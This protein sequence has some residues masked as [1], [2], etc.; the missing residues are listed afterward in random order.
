MEE[1]E[2]QEIITIEYEHPK[3]WH[4]VMANLMDIIIFV[5]SVI[6]VFI[7][8]RA[9]VVNTPDYLTKEAYLDK[10]RLASGLYVK[11]EKRIITLISYL[12]ENKNFAPSVKNLKSQEAVETYISYLNNNFGEDAAHDFQKIYDDYRLNEGLKYEGV[13]YFIDDGEKIKYN[14]DCAALAKDY[15]NNV[16]YPFLTNNCLTHLFSI[17]TQ[18]AELT[19]EMSYYLLWLELPVAYIVGA[20]LTYFVPPLFFKRGRQ[21]FGKAM[22][23][24]GLVDANI[25]SPSFARFSARFGI[26]LGAELILSLVTFGIPFLISFSMMAFSRRHQGFP[27]YMLGLTEIDA[28]KNRIYLDKVDI[29]LTHNPPHKDPPDFNLIH[30]E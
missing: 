4:R 21:T 23:H 11:D 24:I 17:N 2:K 12:E 3:F 15:Y 28:S 18:Y 6:L 30:K 1:L 5:L 13:P 8:I 25:F 27:D 16:Y 20:I 29:E 19:K 9:I 7:G 22:Y 14:P 26:F 10:T